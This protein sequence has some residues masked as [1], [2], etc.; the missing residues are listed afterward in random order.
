M[1]ATQGCVDPSDRNSKGESRSCFIFFER[2]RNRLCTRHG[3]TLLAC[4][5]LL[6]RWTDL[7]GAIDSWYGISDRMFR[8]PALVGPLAGKRPTMLSSSMRLAFR[9]SAWSYTLATWRVVWPN[10]IALMSKCL[11]SCLFSWRQIN[12]TSQYHTEVALFLRRRSMS[13]QCHGNVAAQPG[14]RQGGG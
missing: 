11:A 14:W 5:A 7:S 3:G 10:L 8:G 4:D 6:R 13:R 1:F 12:A 2:A 9:P